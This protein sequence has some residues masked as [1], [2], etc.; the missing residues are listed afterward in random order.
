MKSTR[1]LLSALALTSACAWAQG[2]G[3][4]DP[5]I[6][7]IVV[8]ANQA[9]ID[10]GKLAESK[11]NS[12]DVKA[13]AQQMVKDHTGVNKAAVDLVQKLGVKPEANPTSDSLK[14]GGE[15]NIANLKTLQG[16]KF[17]RAYID[18]EVTY[19]QDVIDALDKTLIPSAQNAELKALL[20]KVRPAFVA[21]LEHA[22]MVRSSLPQAQ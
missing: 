7:A 20:V 3:P 15:T 10:A 19:H 14:Q 1:W 12:K 17:D 18:H 5:Q 8:A 6:A 22:K 4:T 11:T 13:F 16:A 2:S 21:H 9:D